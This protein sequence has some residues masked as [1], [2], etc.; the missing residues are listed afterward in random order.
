MCNI[1][2]SRLQQLNLGSLDVIKINPGPTFYID[3]CKTISA[4]YSQNSQG[5]ICETAGQQCLCALSKKLPTRIKTT[6]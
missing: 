4:P 1:F 2:E 6:G 3:P 5:V